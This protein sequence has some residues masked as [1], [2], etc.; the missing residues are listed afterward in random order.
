LQNLP[1]TIIII[2][3]GFFAVFN[4]LKY[5]ESGYGNKFYPI[6]TSSMYP[7]IKPGSLVYSQK[8][9]S[10]NVG[11][12]VSYTEKTKEGVNTGKVFTHRIISATEDGMFILKGDANINSDPLEINKNQI[13]GR[14]AFIL[15]LLGYVEV[16]T[17]S[18]PGFLVFIL[19]PCIF[20]LKRQ[21]YVVRSYFKSN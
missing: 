11:D 16:I 4:L 1:E 10:Y 7:N 8:V 18:L 5:M 19:V 21:F 3:I 17:K 13:Q 14:V 20:L 15:P 12:I 9:D 2:F 6:I